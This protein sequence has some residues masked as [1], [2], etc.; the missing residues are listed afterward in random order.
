[1]PEAVPRPSDAESREP[2]ALPA[3][4]PA[5]GDDEEAVPGPEE[6]LPALHAEALQLPGAGAREEG[7]A[8]GDVESSH[9][10]PKVKRAKKNSARPRRR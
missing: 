8:D 4:D 10:G 7:E 6:G 3:N 5:E 2:A 9:G 1:M